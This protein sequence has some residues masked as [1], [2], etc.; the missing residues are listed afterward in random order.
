MKDVVIFGSTGSVGRSALSVIAQN[1]K[2]FKVKGLSANRD[3]HTLKAQI[4]K[5]NPS[6]VCV[7]DEDFAKKIEP[8]V[9]GKVKLLK[10]EKGLEEFS[11]LE[12]DISV[13]AISGISAL[14]PL[15]MNIQYTKRVALANKESIVAAAPIIF[16]QANKFN[17]EIIP[18]DSEINAFFQL[19]QF[20]ETA[21]NEVFRKVYL[22]A[23]GGALLG[24]KKEDFR[25]VTPKKVLNHPTWKMGERITV[26]STT[27]VNKAF[28]VIE[29]HFFFGIPYEDISIV[30][31]KESFVHAFVE[32]QDNTLLACLYPP[33]MKMPIAHA[34]YYPKRSQ[35][36]SNMNFS[37]A[38]S[39]SFAP[40]SL[41][42]Y[43]LLKL[44]L[45]AAQKGD[46]SLVI[47]NACDEVLVEA[48]LEKRIKFTDIFK[49]MRYMFNKYESNVI[50][51]LDDVFFW[52]LWARVKT[53]ERIQKI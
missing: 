1:R 4:E 33:D 20:K 27:L 36:K 23:S 29:T 50:N 19:M 32:F 46:N 26:D 24:C 25:K 9:N 30:L 45:A 22:T 8:F 11:S 17:T 42:S 35:G 38:F 31:H 6:Y 49:I 13:M 7:C 18:V 53:R 43:P 10:G 51:T 44:I 47:L 14:K 3:I 16:S 40:L 52:D 2:D 39:C 15:L 34:L 21:D 12:S 37:K 28:E 5:F 48:F 41:N